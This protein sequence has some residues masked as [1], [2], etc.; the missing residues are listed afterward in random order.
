[1]LLGETRGFDFIFLGWETPK[2]QMCKW[3]LEKPC[4]DQIKKGK[5][6]KGS[7]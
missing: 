7:H 5:I 4:L 3:M 2:Y 6:K 1:M